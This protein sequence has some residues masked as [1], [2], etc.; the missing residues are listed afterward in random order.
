MYLNY[1]CNDPFFPFVDLSHNLSSNFTVSDSFVEEDGVNY[2]TIT[3]SVIN[4]K[5]QSNTE[6]DNFTKALVLYE[7]MPVS[8]NYLY[9]VNPDELESFSDWKENPVFLQH[10]PY[11][12]FIVGESSTYNKINVIKDSESV[13]LKI[14]IDYCS[15]NEDDVSFKSLA[16]AVTRFNSGI[17]S[18]AFETYPLVCFNFT[19]NSDICEE[20]ETI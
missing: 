19:F 12:N 14:C 15:Q 9:A 16:L 18:S 4:A 11:T 17:V 8:Y 13:K 10:F 2:I 3:N 20:T 7:L 5:F 6:A 1:N